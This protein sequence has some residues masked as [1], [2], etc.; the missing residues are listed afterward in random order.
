MAKKVRPIP[1]EYHS[2]TPG[3]AVKDADA[4][5]KFCKKAFGARE[6]VRM[7]GPGGG[8]MHAEL[9]IGDS[10]IMTG[11]ETPGFATKAARTLGGTPVNLMI[12]VEK[13]DA[14]FKKALA[15]GATVAMPMSD[16][17]WGDRYGCVTDPFG[18]VWG[19]ATHIEDVPPREMKKR[20]AKAMADMAAGR[21][22]S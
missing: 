7:P 12:Y 8:V 14:V 16:M 13:A 2:V 5:I 17:F 22:P 4:F 1:K 18:N 21:Q 10:R 20:A 3:L 15:A 11:D 19:I 6:M 9:Q